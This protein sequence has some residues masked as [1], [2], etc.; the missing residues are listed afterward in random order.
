MTP[1]FSLL[2]G[3]PKIDYEHYLSRFKNNLRGVL[4]LDYVGGQIQKA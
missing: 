4:G 2:C 3:A 1:V